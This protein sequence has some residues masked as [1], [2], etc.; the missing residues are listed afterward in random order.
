V[1]NFS[2]PGSVREDAGGHQARTNGQ[3]GSL[4]TFVMSRMPERGRVTDFGIGGSEKAGGTAGLP[5]SVE[6]GVGRARLAAAKLLSYGRNLQGSG[7]EAVTMGEALSDLLRR[8]IAKQAHLDPSSIT[9]GSALAELGLTSLDLVEIITT[10]E[11]EYNVTIP[12]DAA[13]ASNNY[14]TV[15]DLIGLGRSLGLEGR[16]RAT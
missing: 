11:D 13:E 14:K 10:I 5:A 15:A 4:D 8:V 9:P 3:G 12:V 16:R 7:G 1:A 2:F 6:Q